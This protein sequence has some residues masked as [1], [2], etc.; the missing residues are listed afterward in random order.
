MKADPS[1]SDTAAAKQFILNI[2][3]KIRHKALF[4]IFN[5]FPVI[6]FATTPGF[7]SSPLHVADDIRPYDITF[8][9]A[10]LHRI[11]PYR[12]ICFGL[13]LAVKTVGAS[14]NFL[15]T[16]RSL[17]L[18]VLALSER[19]EFAKLLARQSQRLHKKSCFCDLFLV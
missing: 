16:L 19:S 14:S 10:I 2:N 12:Y 6:Y 17:S 11:L 4:A 1:L 15:Q 5:L 18:R 13:H 8:A 9:H 3:A 7:Q